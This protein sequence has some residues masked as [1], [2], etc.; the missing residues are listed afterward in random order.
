MS[1]EEKTYFR[2]QTNAVLSAASGESVDPNPF[3]TEETN[4]ILSALAGN[5]VE[6]NPFFGEDTNAI[7]AAIKAGGGGGGGGEGDTIPFRKITVYNEGGE[8]TVNAEE[9]ETE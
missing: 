6:A 9:D 1:D 4:A 7:I 3:Y 8:I 2:G 5:D